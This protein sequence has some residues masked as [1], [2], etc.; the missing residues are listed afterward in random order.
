[1]PYSYMVHVTTVHT[2]CQQSSALHRDYSAALLV[3]A[4][5][6]NLHVVPPSCIG[7]AALMSR[8]PLPAVLWRVQGSAA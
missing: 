4:S 7:Q 1:M 3:C 2:I 8:L 5:A 6:P